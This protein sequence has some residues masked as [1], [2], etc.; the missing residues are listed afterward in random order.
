MK[1]CFPDPKTILEVET[2]K[3]KK[4]AEGT[5]VTD[6]G[7]DGPGRASAGPFKG[8]RFTSLAELALSGLLLS[9]A[10]LSQ[11]LWEEP[12]SSL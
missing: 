7:G 1:D 9:P 11:A 2:K 6:V 4:K 5:E 3:K 12:V 8:F 10:Y